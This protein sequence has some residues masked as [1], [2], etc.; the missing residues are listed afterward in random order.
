MMEDLARQTS[1]HNISYSY[2]VNNVIKKKISQWDKTQN[3]K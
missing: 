2:Q 3:W 1:E